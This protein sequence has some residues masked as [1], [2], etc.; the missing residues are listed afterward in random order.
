VVSR[1]P[2]SKPTR[3]TFEFDQFWTIDS[4]L[5]YLYSTAFCLR[6]LFGDRVEPFEQ[7]LRKELT[8]FVTSDQLHERI[9]ASA[10]VAWK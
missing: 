8:P 6:E 2:F 3:Y 1:S 5:G 4:F 9:T 7:D 10:L